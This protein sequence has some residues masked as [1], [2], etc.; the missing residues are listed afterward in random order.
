MSSGTGPIG[1][2]EFEIV[3][4]DLHAEFKEIVPRER[5]SA[6]AREELDAFR[7]ARV[8]DFVPIFAWRQAR[9]R[10]LAELSFATS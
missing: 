9:E 6:I 3:E 5:L 1:R 10:V 2:D 8:R 4:H 7:T